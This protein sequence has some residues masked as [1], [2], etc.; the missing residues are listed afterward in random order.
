MGTTIDCQINARLSL[1]IEP[2]SIAST[3]NEKLGF[4]FRA[5]CLVMSAREGYSRPVPRTNPEHGIS[6]SLFCEVNTM[7]KVSGADL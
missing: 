2:S 1:I 3:L 4:D 5:L 7:P 6:V